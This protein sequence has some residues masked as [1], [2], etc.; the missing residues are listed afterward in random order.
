VRS[1]RTEPADRC[2]PA[3]RAT[4]WGG[5]AGCQPVFVD[6]LTPEIRVYKNG[7]PAFAADAESSLP[8]GTSFIGRFTLVQPL[9]PD[10]PVY[11]AAE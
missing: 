4:L 2:P 6:D 7:G 9:G 1:S 10:V 5:A 8:P 11:V 3:I